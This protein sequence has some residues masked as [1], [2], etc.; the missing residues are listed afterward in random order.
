M[1]LTGD[2]IKADRAYEIGLVNRVV[3]DGEV[4]LAKEVVRT[5][6]GRGP[7]AV[8]AALKALRAAD[9]PLEQGLE[10]EA[11]LFSDLFSTAD[12]EEGVAAFLAR[13][14]AEFKGR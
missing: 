10:R 9:H 8:A 6:A 2:R 14:P 1:I 11:A 3:D 4:D 13:R 7:V 5:I 12:V